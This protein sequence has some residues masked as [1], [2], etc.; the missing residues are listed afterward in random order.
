M[1]R[2]ALNLPTDLKRE[3]EQIAEKQGVS[4]NQFIMWS[5]SEKV[6]TMRQQLDD[7]NFPGVHLPTRRVGLGHACHSRDRHSRTN[8]CGGCRKI[9]G[10]TGR[11]CQTIQ[12]EYCSSA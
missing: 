1:T 8:C 7:P 9:E 4:L 3:A 5:V 12:F 10:K 6:A 2:Y 11:V